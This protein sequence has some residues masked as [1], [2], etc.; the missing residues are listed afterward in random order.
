MYIVFTIIMF[1]CLLLFKQAVESALAIDVLNSSTHPYLF[2]VVDHS[3]VV[4]K[5][6]AGADDSCSHRQH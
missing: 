1:Y 3:S 5:L 4:T 6:C 2:W